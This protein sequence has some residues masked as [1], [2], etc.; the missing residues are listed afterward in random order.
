MRYG[1]WTF[2][3]GSATI[4]VLQT[5]LIDRKNWVDRDV[6]ILSSGLARLTPGTNPLSFCVGIGWPLRG[7]S[8]AVSV[9]LA[10]SIPCSVIALLVTALYETWSK[11]RFVV[12]CLRGALGATVRVMIATGWTLIRPCWKSVSMLRLILFTGTGLGFGL[13]S[14]SPIRVLF[15]AAS[16][17]HRRSSSIEPSAQIG[18]PVR[19]TIPGKSMYGPSRPMVWLQS[20]QRSLWR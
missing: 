13:A 5:E 20:M 12:V 18:T 19:L 9:L 15:A 17:L 11:N 10:G 8:G 4:A 7:F 16:R 3:A 14:V 2:G 1:N 6:C